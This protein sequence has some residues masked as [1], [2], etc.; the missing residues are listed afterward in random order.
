M[1]DDMLSGHHFTKRQ[2]EDSDL[3]SGFK[4][5]VEVRHVTVMVKV[6]MVG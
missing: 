4:N 1:F 2:F 6:K 3:A 5:K